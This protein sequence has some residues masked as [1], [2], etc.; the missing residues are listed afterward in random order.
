MRKH[1]IIMAVKIANMAKKNLYRNLL[2]AAMLVTGSGPVF[3]L[4]LTPVAAHAQASRAQRLY[5]KDGSYQAVNE[6]K[7]TGNRVRYYSAE[8][9]AWEEIPKSLV[10]WDA[11]EK[12]KKTGV[13]LT[14]EEIKDAAADEADR[15]AEEAKTPEV[16]PGV[17][18]PDI[19][20]AYLLDRASTGVQ[21]VPLNPNNGAVNRQMGKNIMRAIINPLPTGA[22]QTIELKGPRATVQAH[23]NRPEFFVSESFDDEPPI[24]PPPPAPAA[25][26]AKKSGVMTVYPTAPGKFV[27][28]RLKPKKDVRVL[29]NLNIS[30]TGKVKEK[31][32]QIDTTITNLT[33]GWIKIS[34]TAALAPGEYALVEMLGQQMNL[35]VY[36]FGVDANAAANDA[37]WKPSAAVRRRW[38]R[39]PRWNSASRSSSKTSSSKTSSSKTGHGSGEPG[40][41][42]SQRSVMLFWRPRRFRWVRPVAR[43]CTPRCCRGWNFSPC[44]SSRRPGG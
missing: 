38:K 12:F 3:F 21:L 13:K 27:I 36:D 11:T 31:A 14:A 17:R 35:S 1:P 23:V 15:K 24:P 32:D 40:G 16:A 39:R 28:V 29:G 33:G 34:P 4:F 5:L 25:A 44:T 42:L 19:G 9:F 18:L 37:A 22:K 8:R 41:I 20:G 43:A 7:V 10:D 26:P 6:Y 2:A 30:L